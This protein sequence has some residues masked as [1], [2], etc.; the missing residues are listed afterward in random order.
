MPLG[1]SK[2]NGVKLEQTRGRDHDSCD[3]GGETREQ[4]EFV[5]YDGHRKSSCAARTDILAGGEES[6]GRT[7]PVSWS[8]SLICCPLEVPHAERFEVITIGHFVVFV[9]RGY[10]FLT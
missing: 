3:E 1:V 2:K 5:K 8:A 6:G 7:Q 10:R 9:I 4:Q